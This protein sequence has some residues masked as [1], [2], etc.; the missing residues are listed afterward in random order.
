MPSRAMRADDVCVRG[1][2][3]AALAFAAFAGALYFG[4]RA[5]G[6]WEQPVPAQEPPA[7]APAPKRKEKKVARVSSEWTRWVDAANASCS[8]TLGKVLRLRQPQT[9]AEAER[10]VIRVIE[11]NREWNAQMR[12]LRHPRGFERQA[13]RLRN[14]FT[15]T[16]ALADELLRAFRARDVQGMN[17]L[18]LDVIALE[19]KQ[20]ELLGR[21]GAE[22][23][24]AALHT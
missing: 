4:G 12:A 24:V 20:A 15:R 1:F 13:A 10:Y 18:A 7:V 6:A 22:Q 8:R 2:L 3:A 19:N 23:C 16:D 21:M 14:S 5:M 11:L 9:A 17:T